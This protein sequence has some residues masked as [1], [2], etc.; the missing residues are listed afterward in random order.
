ML[1]CPQSYLTTANFSTHG[2]TSRQR[3]GLAKRNRNGIE[4]EPERSQTRTTNEGTEAH[5]SRSPS[6]TRTEATAA[7]VAVGG[8]GRWC[9]GVRGRDDSTVVP[10]ISTLASHK[11]K[12]E[13]ETRARVPI[14]KPSLRAFL[15]QSSQR[16]TCVP[17]S[18]RS[19]LML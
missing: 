15:L 14:S 10:G 13:P 11:K 7:F 8:A 6:V 3:L 12:M 4:T 17:A 9:P 1:S 18:A 2:F 16:Y 19:L 5:E